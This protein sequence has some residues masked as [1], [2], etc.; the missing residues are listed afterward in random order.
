M[1]SKLKN[2]PT[3]VAKT[4]PVRVT[5]DSTIMRCDGN[6][7]RFNDRAFV[8]QGVLWRGRTAK[9]PCMELPSLLTSLYAPTCQWR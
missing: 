4:I 5:G 3:N 1:K 2:W 6:A 9:N 7:R 8:K